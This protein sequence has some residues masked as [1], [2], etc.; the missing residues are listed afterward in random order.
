MALALPSF[1]NGENGKLNFTD[2]RRHCDSDRLE[3][4]ATYALCPASYR[5]ATAIFLYLC[6][7]KRLQILLNLRPLKH[8]ASLLQIALQLLSQDQGKKT[9]EHVAPDRIIALVKNG[10]GFKHR[11]NIPEHPLHLPQLL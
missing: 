5:H 1:Q 6:L 9:A 2:G 4:L 8:M 10:P 11:L 7:L 3:H